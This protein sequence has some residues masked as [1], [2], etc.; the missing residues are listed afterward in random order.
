MESLDQRE[1]NKDQKRKETFALLLFVLWPKLH[2]VKSELF[3]ACC[4]S[5]ALFLTLAFSLMIDR[6]TRETLLQQE[7]LVISNSI[8]FL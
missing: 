4:L 7:N 2:C 6:V 8:M 1:N 3:L 5:F